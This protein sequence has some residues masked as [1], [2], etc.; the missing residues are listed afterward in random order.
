MTG[1]IASPAPPPTP[2]G[3]LIEA[4]GWFPAINLS[5]MRAALRLGDGAVTDA[6]LT[7]AVEGGIIAALRDLADW[8]LTFAGQGLPDLAAVAPLAR[9]NGRSMAVILWERAVQFLAAAELADLHR[10]L[11]ATN[12]GRDRAEQQDLLADDYRRLAMNALA[13]LKSIGAVLP[14]ARNQVALV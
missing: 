6:R 14:F 13:D 8:R 7:Q 2:P 4:D 10:D 11:S 1:L 5:Q 12:D 9:V 3:A